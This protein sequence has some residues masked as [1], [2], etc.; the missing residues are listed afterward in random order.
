MASTTKRPASSSANAAVTHCQVRLRSAWSAIPAETP[1]PCWNCPPGSAPP[2]LHGEAPLPRQLTLTAGVERAFLDRCR[3][4]PQ[5]VQTLLLVAA[6]DAT[7]R[8]ATVRQAAAAL[9]ADETAWVD[10][11]RSNLLTLTGD[12]VAVRHPLVRSAVYQAATS[13]EQRQVHRALAQAV[14][15]EDP[16]RATWHRAAAADGPDRDV[17]AALA[18]VAVRAEQRG[19]HLAAADAFERSAA[20]TV[21]EADRATRLFGAARTAWAAGQAI[22]A[23]A[24]A[25]SARELVVDPLQRAGHRPAPGTHRGQRRL[26]SGRAPHLHRRCPH[27]RR[28]RHR[29]R[30][31]DGVRSRPEPHVRRRQRR[32][33]R[34]TPDASAGPDQINARTACLRL[35]LGT[36]TASGDQDWARAT[37]A[38]ARALA[39]GREVQDLDVM[40]N[41]G[42][43]ALP[44]RP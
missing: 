4:L 28:T 1:S 36:L 43:T 42:N 16:D 22:R 37:P 33:R 9:G 20:L 30:P 34:R 7:G 21:N 11:E 32:P 17:A 35:L 6:A 5:E 25:S 19:G 8:V 23:R 14:G 12:T 31:G 24:L 2:R 39:A 13:F 29:S 18:D 41:L 10:A 40:G 38:L 27:G 15:A 44:P 26:R 3:L